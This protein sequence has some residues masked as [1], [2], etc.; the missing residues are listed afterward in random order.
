MVSSRKF[1]P[2][3]KYIEKTKINGADAGSRKVS[4]E[5]LNREA[6]DA[7]NGKAVFGL[8]FCLLVTVFGI[9]KAGM[10]PTRDLSR[11]GLTLNISN[12]ANTQQSKS[13]SPSTQNTAH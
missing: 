7:Q 2:N 5:Q 1:D 12:V 8:V 3:A 6:Q 9:V 13:K 10:W 4:G 11:S